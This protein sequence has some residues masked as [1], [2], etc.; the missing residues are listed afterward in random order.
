VSVSRVTELAG[1]A[2]AG[3]AGAAYLP[4]IWHLVRAHCSAGL[5]KVAFGAWLAASALIMTNAIAI[6]AGAFILLGSIQ[7]VAT[8]LILAFSIRYEH[9]YCSAHRPCPLDQGLEAGAVEALI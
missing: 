7:L 3:I 1:F 5:S 4:Q 8:A 9:S 2:G 6:H